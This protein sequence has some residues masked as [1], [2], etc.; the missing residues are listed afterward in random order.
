MN[1]SSFKR[2]TAISV[3]AALA[4]GLI[5]STVRAEDVPTE[6]AVDNAG[7]GTASIAVIAD[8]KAPLD[9]ADYDDDPAGEPGSEWFHVAPNLGDEPLQMA[10]KYVVA[11]NPADVAELQVTLRTR[12]GGAVV[13]ET[14]LPGT[15]GL[16]GAECNELLGSV[17]APGAVADGLVATGQASSEE[18]TNL[19]NRC[20]QQTAG[21]WQVAFPV[22]KHL[23][24]GWYDQCVALSHLGGGSTPRQCVPIRIVEVTGYQT[25]VTGLSF[26]RL[27]QD[28][29]SID[30]GN[31][32][33][34]D[35]MGTIMGTGNTSP[36]LSVAYSWMKNDTFDPGAAK[37]IK[38]D[39][40]AQ[41]NRRDDSGLIVAFDRADGLLGGADPGAADPF[42]GAGIA[43][44]R[45]VCLEPNEPLKLDFSVTPRQVLYD[46]DYRGLV[47]L[48]IG[49]DE[50]T[51]SA[52]E[53]TLGSGEHAGG[54]TDGPFNNLPGEPVEQALSSTPQEPPAEEPAEEPTEEPAGEPT[55]EPT[56]E[57][58]GEPGA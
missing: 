24:P 10:N 15:E 53:P 36:V 51:E 18:I 54:D 3:G 46:G 2:L 52:C 57:P 1:L 43:T 47:R 25:D 31:F 45:G 17:G 33:L 16:T 50:G 23:P 14:L 12:P 37:Y 8:L 13:W 34:G 19:K 21:V 22:S 26:G 48:T 27:R 55:E 39:F 20:T 4:G 11:F 44:L 41:I 6:G 32:D 42:A 7:G 40:D 35:D 5:V 28:I 56:E 58:A 49:L 38:N 30:D 9:A 29:R